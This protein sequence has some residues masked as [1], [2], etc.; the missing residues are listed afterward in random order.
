MVVE[1]NHKD[2]KDKRLLKLIKLI[3]LLNYII[4]IVLVLSWRKPEVICLIIEPRE[5]TPSII[6]LSVLSRDICILYSEIISVPPMQESAMRVALIS[7]I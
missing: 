3:L 1:N 6:L 4:V 7:I 5:K 2:N